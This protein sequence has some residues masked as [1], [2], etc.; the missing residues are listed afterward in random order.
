MYTSFDPF[1]WL[2]F[3][4][5]ALCVHGQHVAESLPVHPRLYNEFNK[6][7]PIVYKHIM[8][9]PGGFDGNCAALVHWEYTAAVDS[10]PAQL[11][12]VTGYRAYTQGHT[13]KHVLVEN[14]NLDYPNA[15]L[16]IQPTPKQQPIA[17][18]SWGSSLTTV[19]LLPN[20]SVLMGQRSAYM[21][22][23]PSQWCCLFTEALEPSDVRPLSM[24]N[25]LN[26]L[27]HEELA[28]L[29]TIGPHRFVGLVLLPM[30]YTWTL[31]SV[32]DLRAVPSIL[33]NNALAALR[34][35]D[36]TQAWSALSLSPP[37]ERDRSDAAT[38]LGFSLARDIAQRLPQ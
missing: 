29:G 33:L 12:I 34:P 23:N 21:Q 3:D 37:A 24:D 8:A 7:L 1:Y 31:V 18:L 2:V 6:M 26:R 10:R 11:R 17:S 32:L 14:A 13:L 36:E 27:A 19:V 28:N 16:P 25:L 20:N 4:P 9:T 22:T 15:L 30:S 5:I 38:I 35:N